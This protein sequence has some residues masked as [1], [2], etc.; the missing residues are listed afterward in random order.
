ML[1]STQT[2]GL[3]G[4]TILGND[5]EKIGDVVDVYFD[6]ETQQAAWV[7]V[8]S[9]MFGR[10]SSFIPLAGASLDDDGLHVPYDKE[11][12]K[13][14]P[15]VENE[16]HIEPA[17]ESQLSSHYGLSGRHAKGRDVADSTPAASYRDTS[18]PDTDDAM[19]RSEE[20][21]N[22]GVQSYESGRVR[23]RKYVITEQQTVTVPVRREEVRIEREPVTDSNVGAAMDGPA[24]SE[25]EHE[26]VLYAER[27]VVARE[28]VPVE[29]VRMTTGTVTEQETVSDEVRKEQIEVIDGGRKD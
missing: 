26:V 16:D 23:L 9:G 3:I 27:P 5:D 7:S 13:N 4:C 18:R 17:E 14:A 2:S 1:D 15:S 8:H 24:I 25:A 12:I 21:L 11:T 28:A 29:R 20:H 19:T 22:V 10:S 6:D